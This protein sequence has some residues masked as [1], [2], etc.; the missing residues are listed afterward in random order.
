M[1]FLDNHTEISKK[2][3]NTIKQFVIDNFKSLYDDKRG[4]NFAI[5]NV[6]KKVSDKFIFDSDLTNIFSNDSYIIHDKFVLSLERYDDKIDYEEKCKLVLKNEIFE[7]YNSL[8]SRDNSLKITFEDFAHNL[9]KFDIARKITFRLEDNPELYKLHYENN[10]YKNINFDYFEGHIINSLLY[11]K[12]FKKFYPNKE[13]PVAIGTKSPY[14]NI[15]YE[16]VYNNKSDKIK[17][18][19]ELIKS[20]ITKPEFELDEKLLI[21]NLCLV[22]KNEIP[23]TEKIKLIILMGEINDFTI[24]EESSSINNLYSKVNK[25]IDRKGSIPNI[26]NLI[27]NILLKIEPFELTITN[28]RLRIHKAK[29]NLEQNKRIIN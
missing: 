4:A 15:I 23:D 10:D 22:D 6:V 26:L 14:G 3:F 12:L 5:D 2:E 7:Y 20:T 16:I 11:K 21:L 27:N 19:N 13:A 8:I 18:S 17:L 28:Q 24:F 9:I 1:E 29:L 25:G